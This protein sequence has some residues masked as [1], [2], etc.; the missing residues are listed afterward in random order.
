MTEPIVVL[1]G[2]RKVY[3]G[4]SGQIPAIDNLSLELGRRGSVHGFLGPNGSGKTTTIRCVLGLIRPT[5]GSASVFGADSQSAF[6]KVAS[7]V[8]SVVESPKLFPHFSARRNLSLLADLAG[9]SAVSVDQALEVVGLSDRASDHFSTFSLGMKQRLAIAAALLKGPE[10]LLLDEPANGLDPAGIAEIRTLLRR[11]AD[12]GAAVVVSSHQL[13][14]VE[15]VCDDVSIINRGKLVATGTIDTIRGF[16][17]QDSAVIT[18]AE[19]DQAIQILSAAGF[20]AHPLPHAS[21]LSVATDPT[22]TAEINRTLADAQLYLSGLEVKQASLESA[23]LNLTGGPPP[24][25]GPP[26]DLSTSP[27]V[28]AEQ[29][30]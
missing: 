16:A 23:F 14:E 3:S 11:L 4:R 30:A 24:P 15:Q 7:R 8:G 20:K 27:D 22:R 18:I 29:G 12:S 1:D 25:A 6:H 2:L 10:L 26:V 13:A 28:P 9:L 5:Q 17:G 21:K 19:R